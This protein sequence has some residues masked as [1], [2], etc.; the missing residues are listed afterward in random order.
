MTRFKG[1]LQSEMAPLRWLQRLVIIGDH[2]L[3]NWNSWDY[4]HVF[5]T[6]GAFY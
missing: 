5:W 2:W 3:R 1:E 6:R 4:A